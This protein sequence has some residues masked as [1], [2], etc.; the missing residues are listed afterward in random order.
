VNTPVQCQ[1]GNEFSF[2]NSSSNLSNPKFL[3]DFGDGSFDSS[4]SATL[5]HTYTNYG[6]F[7]VK[8]T[9]LNQPSCSTERFTTVRV[10]P[11]P[12]P[13]F[14]GP[15][16]ICD[17]DVGVTFIDRSFV[18]S[19]MGVITNWQWTVDG[20]NYSTQTL[21]QITVRHGGSLPVSLSV[22]TA[23]GCRSDTLS[24]SLPVRHKPVATFEY[25]NALCENEIVTFNN[26]SHIPSGL[27]DEY[28]DKWTWEFDRVRSSVNQ[29]PSVYFASGQHRAYLTVSTNYGCVSDVLEKDLTVNP[30]PSITLSMNDSCVHKDIFYSARDMRNDVINWYWDFGH[31][32]AKGSNEVSKKFAREGNQSFIL[33][34][35]TDKG[36]KDTINR[37]FIIYDNDSYAGS[38]TL[39]ARNQPVFLDAKG[40]NDVT[41]TWSPAAG[42]NN[43]NIE[44][45]VATLDRDIEYTLYSITNKGCE[46]TSNIVIKRYA[47]A[48]IYIPNAFTPN[49]DGKNDVLKVLPIGFK[50]FDYMAVYNR[51]G[52][53]VY[54]THD[55]RQGWDGTIGGRPQDAGNYVVATKMTDYNGKVM[56]RKGNVVL[57]R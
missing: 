51:Y 8:L 4:G 12:V 32:L 23:D 31:G 34:A 41:Y 15:S 9:A 24:K 17:Q 36:C 26:I 33:I 45:P 37:T 6:F 2:V 47:G 5:K 16:V 27:N 21:P 43:P 46:H 20:T 22:M 48:E 13:A 10:M 1:I 44:K 49:G 54:I 42:L 39:V 35:E 18:P 57:L 50:S 55:W 29:H 25:K 14:D 52:Q 38:D 56:V 28:I 53:Q 11:K 40:G 19:Y 7:N 3:W 30:K